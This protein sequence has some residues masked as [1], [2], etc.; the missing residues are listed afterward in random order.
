MPIHE[1]STMRSAL[2][3]STFIS[4]MILGAGIATSAV[5]QTQASASN[6]KARCDQLISYYDRF[7]VGRSENSDGVRNHTRIAA[8]LDCEQGHYEVGIASMETLLKNKHFDGDCPVRG[9]PEA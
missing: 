4:A 2:L 6:L 3:H 1:T 7:G 8:G 5:A 9:T